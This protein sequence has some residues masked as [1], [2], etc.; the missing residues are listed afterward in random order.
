MFQ[1]FETHANYG[2]Q[3]FRSLM[4]SYAYFVSALNTGIVE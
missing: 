2:V 1:T 4:R 3:I